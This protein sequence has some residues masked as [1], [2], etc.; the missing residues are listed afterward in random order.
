MSE[1]RVKI[2]STSVNFILVH[3]MTE[4]VCFLKPDSKPTYLNAQQTLTTYRICVL[5]LQYTDSSID[6]WVLTSTI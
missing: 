6:V 2:Y 5:A 3:S 1:S 4:Y